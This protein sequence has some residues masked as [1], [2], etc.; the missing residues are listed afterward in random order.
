M[1]WPQ[2]QAMPAD[3]KQTGEF[4]QSGEMRGTRNRVLIV[5][6]DENNVD[7]LQRLLQHEYDLATAASGEACLKKMDDFRPDVVLLDI[8]MPGIDGYEICRRIKSD[9]G[10]DVAQVVLNPYPRLRD[11]PL[12]AA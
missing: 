5:D 4:D 10:D 11:S 7:I 3:P 1:T 8:M 6:D 12:L 9:P 2:P